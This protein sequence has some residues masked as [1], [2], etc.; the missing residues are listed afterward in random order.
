MFLEHN[1]E[2]NYHTTVGA[3]LNG[4]GQR[5]GQRRGQDRTGQERTGQ[6]TGQKTGGQRTGQRTEAGNREKRTGQDRTR[7]ERT[8]Q[9]SRQD[10]GEDRRQDRRSYLR[11]SFQITV[12]EDFKRKSVW[13][14]ILVLRVS[15]SLQITRTSIM[16]T[17]A[18]TRHLKRV[19]VAPCTV[20][21]FL[22]PSPFTIIEK[23]M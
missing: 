14:D 3:I 16:T 11:S 15:G 1:A 19:P 12:C 17:P 21:R 7:Q 4:T 2:F 8:G 6:R 18:G 20:Q 10:K 22:P 9:A 23:S 13:D 5:T